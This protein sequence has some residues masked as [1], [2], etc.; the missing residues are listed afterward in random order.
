MRRLEIAVSVVVEAP[1]FP[2]DVIV[3]LPILHANGS[4]LVAAHATSDLLPAILREHGV[5]AVSLSVPQ[6]RREHCEGR[7]FIPMLRAF[8]LALRDEASR[9]VSKHDGGFCFVAMLSARTRAALHLP[10]QIGGKD[11]EHLRLRLRECGNRHRARVNTPA[12]FIRRHALPAM[13]ARFIREQLACGWACQG[14][15]LLSIRSARR[16]AHLFVHCSQRAS[17]SMPC[18]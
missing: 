10:F 13:A 6:P 11:A 17:R 1:A 18:P 9:L 4:P 8:G 5:I 15:S 14:I 2:G 3:N 12:L 7:G 16:S